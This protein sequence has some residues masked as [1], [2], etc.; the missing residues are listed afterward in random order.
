MKG[1]ARDWAEKSNCHANRG[2]NVGSYT[3]DFA[4]VTSSQKNKML[5]SVDTKLPNLLSDIGQVVTKDL[6]RV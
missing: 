6:V 4:F 3:K 1:I 5:V 2:K